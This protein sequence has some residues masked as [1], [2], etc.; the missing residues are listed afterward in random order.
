MYIYMYICVNIYIPGMFV[1][2]VSLYQTVKIDNSNI[3][4][5]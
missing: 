1:L 2:C 4:E 5:N 3:K